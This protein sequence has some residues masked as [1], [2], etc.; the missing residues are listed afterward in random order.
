MSARRKSGLGKLQHRMFLVFLL[1]LAGA[2]GSLAGIAR[3]DVGEAFILG[4]DAAAFLFIQAT[5]FELNRAS[6]ARLRQRASEN[7]AGRALLPV[8]AGL[9][10]AVVLLAL[11][12]ELGVG[13]E[14]PGWQV[15]L[16]VMTLAIAWLFGNVVCALHYAH[17]FYDATPSGGD[18]GG[19]VFPG[20]GAPGFWDFCYFAFVLGMTFQVSDVQIASAQIRRAALLHGLIAFFFNIGVVALTVNVIAGAI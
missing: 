9:L 5:V 4:F 16:V 15:V 20:S 10:L 19:L 18:K 17:L 14:S 3:I 1:V 12:L 2:F 11:G 7:D 6:P 8:I 13:G